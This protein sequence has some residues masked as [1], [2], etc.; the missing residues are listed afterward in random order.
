MVALGCAP[1]IA[2]LMCHSEDTEQKI[3]NAELF[4]TKVA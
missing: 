1:D 2:R 3:Y 4:Q